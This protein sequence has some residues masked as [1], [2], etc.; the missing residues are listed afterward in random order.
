MASYYYLISSLP[1]LR[2][3]DAPPLDYAAFLDQ[4]RGAVSDRVYRSL[5][6]L[7]VRSE[8]GG[9]VSRWAAFYRVL[10]GELTYQRRVKRGESCAAPNER[11]AAVTQTVTAAVNAKDPL[12]GERLL[13]ALE[14]DRLDELVGGG[15]LADS[16]RKIPFSGGKSFDDC[17]LYGYA[18]K[19]QLLERQRVFRHD[20]GKA[21]F[22]T[23]LGQVRQ[24]IFSL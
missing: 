5:E 15:L 8:D 21:A 23:L 3:G 2:A 19:L 20:E 9:F 10:Q 11:D 24:Q 17:A 7:T 12:E 13:L 22:D 4:C 1:M 18:L 16:L 6:E 14:F